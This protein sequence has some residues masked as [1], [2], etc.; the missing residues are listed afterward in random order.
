VTGSRPERRTQAERRTETIARLV[1]ATIASILEVGYHRT[2]LGEICSRS[3]VSKGGLF[4]HFES[5][6]DLV[7]A[8]ART[9]A[10]RHLTAFDEVRA[11][12]GVQDIEELLHFTRTRA[13]EESN[14][15]WFELLVAARTDADLRRLLAPVAESLYADIE[16][17]A[18][19]SSLAEGQPDHLVRLV[20]TSVL[21]LFDGEAIIRHTYPRPELEEERLA[22]L[23]Q[24]VNAVT[25]RA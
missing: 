3:G 22:A 1:E 23:G 12:G 18:R 20:T 25:R 14:A 5:R 4:R 24:L 2:S 13:R 16:A 15:V 10:D 8:A 21:H 19:E 11:A 6:L 7:V 9:V 17:R